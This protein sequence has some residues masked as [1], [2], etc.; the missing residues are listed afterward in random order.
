MTEIHG[1]HMW[2]TYHV[3]YDMQNMSHTFCV[4]FEVVAQDFEDHACV[5]V[6]VC[7][8]VQGLRVLCWS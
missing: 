6:S 2:L 3:S 5:C 7:V 8:T 4:A 1:G